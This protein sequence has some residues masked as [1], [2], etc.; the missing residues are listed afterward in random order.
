MAAACIFCYERLMTRISPLL[1]AAAAV[2]LPTTPALA[3]DPASCAS[4]SADQSPKRLS[5]GKSF[6]L[7][8]S[9]EALARSIPELTCAADRGDPAAQLALGVRYEEG[10]GV[11][12]D[13]VRAAALYQMAE[14]YIERLYTLNSPPVRSGMFA[15]TRTSGL[16]PP[17]PALAEARF[18]LGRLYLDGRGVTQNRGT[19]IRLLTLSAR[20]GYEPALTLLKGGSS[21]AAP[22]S[23]PADAAGTDKDGLE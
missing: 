14:R 3:K 21:P 2:L 16:R 6:A 18:R 19:G 15:P 1:L 5:N 4:L 22:A 13:A 20:Q 11:A 9:P 23:E 17:P 7:P 10:T 12:A 8:D